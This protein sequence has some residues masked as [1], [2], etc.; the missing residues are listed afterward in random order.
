MWGARVLVEFALTS[1]QRFA[2]LSR[3]L[4]VLPVFGKGD[5][6]FQPVYVGD[7]GLL[8]EILT[9]NSPVKVADGKIIEAAGPDGKFTLAQLWLADR[10]SQYSLDVPPNNATRGGSHGSF[11]A[12]HFCALDIGGASRGSHAA[13]SNKSIHHN[14]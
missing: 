10:D 11:S 9:R 4:P 8:V 1:H 3:Y 13:S 6:R 12:D 2:Q 14:A 7:I 5:T